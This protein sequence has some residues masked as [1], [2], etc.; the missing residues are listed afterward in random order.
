MGRI[1]WPHM[2]LLGRIVLFLTVF[3]AAMLLQ[4]GIGYYQSK[5]VLGPLETRSE[6]IQTISQ[7]LNNVEAC[8]TAL[9]NY[10]WDYGDAAA[11]ITT[12]QENERQSAGHIERIDTDLRVVSEEQYLLANAARTTYQTL[13]HTLD[14]IV[15]ELQAGQSTQASKLYYSSAEP[16]G[17]Y[18]RQY[19]QQ[20]LEQACFDNQD[21]HARLIQLNERLKQAQSVAVLICA[22]IGTMLAMAL[23]RLLRAVAALAQASR[24][25]SRGEFDTQD[26]DEWHNDETG[27]MARAFNEMKHSMKRQVELLNEKRAME[28]QLH[29]K[30]LEAL[31]LQNLMERE[32]LQ[33][34]RSQINPHFL[35]NTLN[36]IL[37]TSQREG[38]EQTY[39]LIGSLS[40]LFRYALGSNESQVPLLRE[41]QIVDEF[42]ALFKA[43]FGDRLRLCWHIGPEIDLPDTL[44]PSF[45]LQPL[46]ENSFKH[47]IAP[48]EEGGCVDIRIQQEDGALKITVTD[49]GAGMSQETLEA[50]RNNLKNPPTTGEHIGVYNVAARLRLW[51]KEYGMDIQSAPGRGTTAVLRLPQILSCEEGDDG[52]QNSGGR[53]REL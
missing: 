41:V 31:E 37:Y 18:L 46:V 33:Q 49:D 12:I 25:I 51:G 35:F 20:L 2:T 24:A 4:M 36:V 23:I 28:S 45:I 19:T 39:A 14:S 47:G 3:A 53:R 15:F 30:E 6:S 1:K 7:F 42:Y 32:K 11:L 5:Y 44:V 13:C 40:R 27:H 52:D 9:E 10:R 26:L 34:L 8:M 48:K 50:L 43:R 21:A 22:A 16:C 29:A 38:A 17:A